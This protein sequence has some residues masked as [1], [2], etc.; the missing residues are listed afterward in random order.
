MM[1]TINQSALT[2]SETKMMNDIGYADDDR[3]KLIIG[4]AADPQNHEGKQTDDEGVDDLSLDESAEGAVS[5][6]QKFGHC[7]VFFLSDQRR[8]KRGNLRSEL[9]LGVQKVQR[10]DDSDD[11]ILD[12]L[13][14]RGCKRSK[15][16]RDVFEKIKAAA[17]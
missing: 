13:H 9:F 11:D 1:I 7:A 3:N 8:K 4:D 6:A 14:R 10:E 2:G 12:L 17:D 15:E 16:G 5:Q